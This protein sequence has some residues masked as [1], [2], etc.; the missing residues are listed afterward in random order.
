LILQVKN[1]GELEDS[2]EM[3]IGS[4]PPQDQHPFIVGET[5]IASLE[6]KVLGFVEGPTLEHE[7]CIKDKRV[8]NR[9]AS[10]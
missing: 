2:K 8:L 9:E 1:V 4:M 7:P 5:F 3:E 6:Y 10:L